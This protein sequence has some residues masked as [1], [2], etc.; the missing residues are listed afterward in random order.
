MKIWIE[1]GTVILNTL[2]RSKMPEGTRDTFT[3]IITML[4]DFGIGEFEARNINRDFEKIADN[5]A[6][7][8][9]GILQHSNL[10]SERIE[11]IVRNI[12]FA[13]EK[14]EITIDKFLDLGAKANEIK[15]I[16]LESNSKYKDDLDPREAEMYERLVEHT[17]HLIENAFI[18]LPS[19][20]QIGIK[21]LS[22]KMDELVEK[23]DIILEQMASINTA[24]EDKNIKTSNFERCYRNNIISQNSYVY[25]FGAGDLSSEYKRYPLSIAYVELEISDKTTGREIKLEKIF[26][27]T[28]NIW[29]SGEAGLGKTTL[30]QWIAVKVAE[31]SE[32]MYGLRDCIPVMIHL[33]KCDCTKLSLKDC[34]NSVMKDSSYTIPEGW[35]DELREMGRFVFLIDGFDE[36]SENERQEVLDWLNQMDDKNKCKKIFTSRPQVKERPVGNKVLEV[37][38]LPM[39]RIRIKKFIKYWHRAVLEEQLKVDK[40]DTISI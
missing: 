37:K 33:R 19:F 22:A 10:S 11:A 13:Y 36:I 23:V 30:L 28:N 24:V 6:I 34:I 4:K 7:S 29:M 40:K 25:L 2:V 27:K 3:D 17:S 16:L 39:D 20:N 32:K 14:A 1:L 12:N 31:K 35:V 15:N 21:R 38:I 26:E 9:S 5:I 18:K 8:C